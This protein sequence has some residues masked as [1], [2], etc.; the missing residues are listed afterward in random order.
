[1]GKLTSWKL[2][3]SRVMMLREWRN[4]SEIKAIL[5][6]LSHIK[7]DL[8]YGFPLKKDGYIKDIG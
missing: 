4:H 1:M 2:H 5:H 8:V 6:K 3:I 7:I